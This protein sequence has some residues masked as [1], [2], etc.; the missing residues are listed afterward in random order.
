MPLQGLLKFVSAW[1]A[2]GSSAARRRKKVNLGILNYLVIRRRIRS[3][4]AF[5][6]DH[7]IW[8]TSA[9]TTGSRSSGWVP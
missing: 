5:R 2:P 9:R 3:A 4:A 6:K 7:S 8:R 1:P